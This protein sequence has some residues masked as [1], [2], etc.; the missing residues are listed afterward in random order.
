MKN[1]KIK[2][3]ELIE[4]EMNHALISNQF[5]VYYQPKYD[6]QT[7]MIAGAEALVRWN[8]PELGILSPDDFI[9]IFE[10]NGFIIQLDR[11]VW[12]TVCRNIRNWRERKFPEVPI[13]V[14][15]SRKDLLDEELEDELLNLLEKYQ[16]SA[17]LLHLEITEYAYANQKD[18]ILK[19]VQRLRKYGFIIEMDNFGSG[20]TSLEML[21]K[22]PVD[23]LKIDMKLIQKET[24]SRTERS[25]L[26]FIV[27]IAKWLDLDVIA[28]G[29][30]NAEQISSLLSM[31]CDYVQGFYY[32]KPMTREAFE[33]MLKT[34]AVME[35]IHNTAKSEHNQ[36]RESEPAIEA[37]DEWNDELG[38]EQYRYILEN[39]DV[40]FLEVNQ[41]GEVFKSKKFSLYALSDN[42]ASCILKKK[43]DYSGIYTDDLPNLFR[44]FR[45]MENNEKK[46]VATLRLKMKD[47]TYR[48]TE[49]T[50]LFEYDDIGNRIK[51]IGIFRDVDKEWTR[52]NKKLQDALHAAEIANQ[53]K[54]DFLARVSHDMRTP[55]NGILGL[56]DIMK[57][58]AVDEGLKSEIE[59]LEL[60]GRYLLNLIDDTIDVGQIESGKLELHSSVCDGKAALETVISMIQPSIYEKQ[61]H[62][63]VDVE[64]LPFTMLYVD[65]GRLEQA[66]INVLSNA[67]KFTP[68]GGTISCKM[69]NISNNNGV[70]VDRLIIKDNG[71]G[72]SKE[73]QKHLYEP[74]MQEHNDSRSVYHGTGL[75]MTITKQCMDLMG[76]SISIESEVGK[77]TEVTLI[78][79]MPIATPEQIE[80]WKK[81]NEISDNIAILKGK[82]VLLCEDH[83]L[84]ATI[85]TKMLEKKGMIIEHATNGREGLDMF[86]ASSLGYYNLILMDIRMPQ[87]DGIEATKA[88]R[89]LERADAKE[90]PIIAMTA[91]ALEEDVNN[92]INAG[93][94]EHLGKPIKPEKLYR[95]LVE[96]IKDPVNE[97]KK[98]ILIVDDIEM[99]RGFVRKAIESKYEVIEASNGTEALELLQKDSHIN[100][101]ITDIQMPF[102]DG[103]ELIRKIREDSHMDHIA[104][105]ANTIY[106]DHRQEDELLAMG[107]N[108][109]VYKP[110][111]A[112]VILMRLEHIFRNW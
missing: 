41:D 26:S 63:Q 3:K 40:A 105:L 60:S 94:S 44:F 79:P 8:H 57:E 7:E 23:V 93:M 22:M 71:I 4:K 35:L 33:V 91:N 73:F 80:E 21:A 28:E 87:M 29:V 89:S 43:D 20:N 81:S 77:G 13:S 90:I 37:I 15:V 14:N 42:N 83:P 66:V 110:S 25:I 76:G 86:V 69:E 11:F 97:K 9:P 103:R 45:Q 53:A 68:A 84:N 111:S 51:S 30:E 16:I 62:F 109:F 108:D 100:A 65:I 75:G 64:Q 34:S 24:Q 59:Q 36:T 67:V 32:A 99:N 85:A 17:S 61:I 88:I 106:G 95:T 72:M 102:M 1:D 31:G 19:C 52:Q 39:L 2:S 55:L 50:G 10:K 92:C 12:D 6:M 27:E 98:R 49:I 48:W 78:L 47:E 104:I 46:V 5:E 107:A 38:I 18:K 82:R 96:F 70:I 74:F 112:R 58:K 101:V 54:T 56:T